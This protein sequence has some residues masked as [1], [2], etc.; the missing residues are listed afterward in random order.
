MPT[1]INWHGELYA[2]CSESSGGFSEPNSPGT[3][4]EVTA[5]AN[6]NRLAWRALRK[7][8]RKFRR[9]R[10]LSQNATIRKAVFLHMSGRAIA[11]KPG[12]NT[13]EDASH[14][15]PIG[16]GVPPIFGWPF[17]L[18]CLLLAIYS[19]I[20]VRYRRRACLR[21]NPGMVTAIVDSGW[22]II[23]LDGTLPSSAR[24]T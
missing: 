16:R 4:K 9:I 3:S 21:V 5:F 24:W 17:S 10:S 11:L 1:R 20:S 22:I 13:S 23:A 15:W 18:V 2:N 6:A 12:R 19:C 8:L 7:L 14:G